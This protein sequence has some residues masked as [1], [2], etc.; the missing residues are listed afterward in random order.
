MRGAKALAA[1]LICGCLTTAAPVIRARVPTVRERVA[2]IPSAKGDIR[3]LYKKVAPATVLVRSRHGFGTGVIIDARGFV[4]TNHHVI[5]DSEN[6]DFKRRVQ[7]ELGTLSAQGYME[8][9]PEHYVAWVLKSDPKVDLAVL[10]LEKAPEGL[11]A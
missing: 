2:G 9:R 8:K 10:K 7:V 4:L 1:L 6:V 3:D 5:A 11:P